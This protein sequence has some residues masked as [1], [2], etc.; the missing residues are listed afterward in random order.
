M[1]P[2]GVVPAHPFAFW[3]EGKIVTTTNGAPIPIRI[4]AVV[5]EE[6]L[7]VG[8]DNWLAI[9]MGCHQFL[10]QSMNLHR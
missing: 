2:G 7:V 1:L 8:K 5:G 4:A 9:R 3:G 6:M 10:P